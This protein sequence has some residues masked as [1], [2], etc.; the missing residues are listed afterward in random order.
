VSAKKD[1]DYIVKVE[2]AIS[3][4]YGEETIQNPKSGWST[5]KEQDYVEQS[6]KLQKKI[7]KGNEEKELVEVNG[8][9]M[10]SKL[11][12]V[13]KSRTCTNCSVYSFNSK[14]GFYMNRY[15]CCFQCYVQW[16]EGREERWLQGWRPD[17]EE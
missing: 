1:L 9:L 2:K 16:V 6:K 7:N 14:D 11:I 13:S 3:K 17:K 12:N 10:P 8:Y 5:E 4:K 15:E